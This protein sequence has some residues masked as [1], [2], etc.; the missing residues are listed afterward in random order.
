MKRLLALM[1]LLAASACA[2][3][4]V[5]PAEDTNNAFTGSNTFTK[6]NIYT[7]ATLPVVGIVPGTFA[8]V[9]DG[10][11]SADCTVGSG[12]QV[13][14]CIW[15][16]SAWTSF[17]GGGGGI[18]P[19]TPGNILQYASSTTGGDTGFAA[20]SVALKPVVNNSACY[21]TNTGNDANDGLSLG[22][23]KLTIHG[24]QVSLPN[25][26]S[27][28]FV[29][30]TGNIFV[31][32]GTSAGGISPGGPNLSVQ[33]LGSNDIHWNNTLISAVRSANVVTLTFVSAHHYS[34][35]QSIN[36]Y[37]TTGGA[38]SFN[39][40]F[41]VV[42]T[43]LTTTLTY[44]QTGANE[45]AT[46]STGAV[47]PTGWLKESGLGDL[48]IYGFG[49]HT[50]SNTAGWANVTVSGGGATNSGSTFALAG[51]NAHY[52]SDG[53]RWTGCQPVALGYD[54][55]FSSSS[56]AG[57][58]STTFT[59]SAFDIAFTNNIGCGPAF[60]IGPNVIWLN[61]DKHEI[62]SLGLTAYNIASLTR[63][64]GVTSVVLS[65][66][67]GGPSTWKTGDKITLTGFSDATFDSPSGTDNG[68]FTIASVTNSTH[69][70]FNNGPFP[71]CASACGSGGVMGLSADN[72]R[73]AS[74]LLD[75]AGGGNSVVLY[76]E[77]GTWNGGGGFRV[78]GSPGSGTNI[79]LRSITMEG[80]GLSQPVYDAIG[81]APPT[82]FI[83]DAQF[84][85]SGNVPCAVRVR[86]A[87]GSNAEP[88][89]T[90]FLINAG[91]QGIPACGKVN[92]INGEMY[93]NI[94]SDD[95]IT[96]PLA[97][98]QTGQSWN[99]RGGTL[100]LNQ[101][102]DVRR[103]LIPVNVPYANLATSS[104]GSWTN[105]T[106]GALTI[107]TAVTDVSHST[108]NACN[109]LV[110]S[111]N[112][113]AD[114]YSGNQTILS[115]DGFIAGGWFQSSSTAGVFNNFFNN[116]PLRITFASAK[117]RGIGQSISGPTNGF[118][119]VDP[120]QQ[121]DGNW[122]WMMTWDSVN[123]AATATPQ[124]VKLQHF[125]VSGYPE[126]LY[127]PM[128]LHV[129]ISAISRYSIS[130]TSVASQT[131]LAVYT[132][133]GTH[134]FKA[135]QIVCINGVSDTSY[136]GCVQII[137]IPSATTIET[138]Y[139]GSSSSSTGGMAYASADSEIAEI[140]RN[141]T[142]YSNS[143]I[144]GQM[145]NFAG[146][147]LSSAA[148]SALTSSTNTT[149]AMVLGTGSSLTVSGSGMNNATTLNGATFAIP[150]TIGGT[151]PGIV[152]D[153]QTNLIEAAAPS[154]VSVKD[155]FYGLSSIH[156]PAFNA[157]NVGERS[158]CGSTGT[159]TSG[160]LLAIN[161]TGTL[162]DLVDGGTGTGSGT[163]TNFAANNI[164]TGT[165]NFATQGVTSPGVT[166]TLTF[167]LANA[168]SHTLFANC[169]GGAA[170]PDYVA[171]TEACM[172]A[173]TVF[174]D[175]NATFG[176]HN[177]SFASSTILKVPA[178][179]GFAATAGDIGLNTTT[180]N[181]QLWANGAN[182][183]AAAWSAAPTNGNCVKALVSTGNVLLTDAACAGATLQ[184]NSVNNT[185]QT[186][187]NFVNTTGASGINFTNPSGGVESAT[188]ASTTGGGNAVL[189]G[190][191]TG[192]ANGQYIGFSGGILQNITPGVVPNIQSGTTYTV[193]QADSGLP[194]FLSN[195]ASIAVTLNAPASYSTG[196]SFCAMASGAGT[197]TITASGNINGAGT[198]AIT[199]KNHACIYTNGS[200]WEALTSVG[201]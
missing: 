155:I 34:I 95:P 147:S 2:Q 168:P 73:R 117:T 67:P 31:Y 161:T 182:K 125:V 44:A 200:T 65:S 197:V 151:T 173:A 163:V 42:S 146:A 37:N 179:A 160:H 122:Q 180:N 184:T 162:C 5:F 52:H 145:C 171:L 88:G 159:L 142:T 177:Y 49:Q 25:G 63:A 4:H 102:D 164:T 66:G 124:N 138:S 87:A 70:T 1:M 100:N 112:G 123:N 190:T 58:F 107:T 45:S 6:L 141:L 10:M 61:V 59:N 84:G 72:D 96:S 188:I 109:L 108:T 47:L 39:G 194:I 183:I 15:T 91:Q 119:A 7:I 79:N 118:E 132:L 150:G 174:T 136:N 126:N 75:T 120:A 134:Q 199:T 18:V 129:P 56:N 41:T 139:S 189:T 176:A 89:N 97:K 121:E 71:D 38:T 32:G 105:V 156:W 81:S 149:A 35:G 131:G 23:A 144:A 133:S 36:V 169:T 68:A 157:N 64:S 127:G 76:M 86:A 195:A 187:Q 181:W 137:Q 106:G 178:G 29:E 110:S 74:V 143:C 90:N 11:T 158:V 48:S 26:S 40:I 69:F 201:F 12:T 114:S 170:A 13:S 21:V 60:I 82:S 19:G 153:T 99:V 53:I 33:I 24:C 192:G 93:P 43:P 166:P 152:N 191:I 101:V 167:T 165:Q 51:T 92:V 54:S 175:Q 140:A 77:H 116:D 14:A 193:L 113:E 83:Y 28:N 148:F 30:G 80:A 8:V 115:G 186:L 9:N 98:G 128:L 55:N 57:A 135:N 198:L 3:T 85:D 111:G 94:T 185:S 196:F 154:G 27:A 78:P 22:T 17:G 50:E 16:G 172:P 130:I 62:T 104:C 46:S 103:G 20:T